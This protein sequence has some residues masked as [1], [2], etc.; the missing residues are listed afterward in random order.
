[1]PPLLGSIATSEPGFPWAE[2]AASAAACR[3][4]S[5][6]SFRFATGLGSFSVNSF[7]A[8]PLPDAGETTTALP[9]SSGL[10]PCGAAAFSWL[11][12][13]VSEAYPAS[14]LPLRSVTAA[15]AANTGLTPMVSLASSFGWI[16]V[17]AQC[18][19]AVPSLIFTT[20]STPS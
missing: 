14:G 19:A 6:V 5:R 9:A 15:G 17:G 10:P 16:T 8:A 1:M 4:A 13:P 18:T 11:S 12:R 2:T 20:P 7:S 3:S